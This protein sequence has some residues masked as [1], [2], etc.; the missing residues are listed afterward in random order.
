MTEKKII[1]NDYSKMTLKEQDELCRQ[2][3]SKMSYED[4]CKWVRESKWY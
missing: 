2:Q 1:I 4:Y 3:A